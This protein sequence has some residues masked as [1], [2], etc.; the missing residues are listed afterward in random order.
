VDQDSRKQA[1]QRAQEVQRF[2]KERQ[3]VETDDERR[4]EK[5][6]RRDRADRSKSS[7]SEPMRMKAR[8]SPIA[9][10]PADQLGKNDAPPKRPDSPQPDTKVERKSKK[11]I[12][13][14]DGRP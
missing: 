8:R 12:E 3:R 13:N 7:R 9:A 4:S 5:V 2:R 14:R 6:D 10:R 1:A 11:T